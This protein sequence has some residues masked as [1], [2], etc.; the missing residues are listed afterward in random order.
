MNATEIVD[1][2]SDEVAD[3][4]WLS[5]VAE[6]VERADEEGEPNAANFRPGPGGDWADTDYKPVPAS[7]ERAAR[8]IL[9]KVPAEV[10]EQGRAKWLQSSGMDDD[11]FA[12]VLAMRILGHGVGLF[13]DIR[14][15]DNRA[16]EIEALDA[17]LPL[18][19]CSIELSAD[20]NPQTN[21]VEPAIA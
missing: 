9:S 1:S 20:W 7:F 14:S 8:R 21:K 15:R 11:R 16:P 17:N 18:L 13:D 12:H 19:D 5:A 6:A 10:L 3:S 4:L 2:I